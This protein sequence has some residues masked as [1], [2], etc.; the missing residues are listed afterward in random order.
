MQSMNMLDQLAPDGSFGPVGEIR[1][2]GRPRHLRHPA[3][4]AALR[5]AAVR[6]A[7]PRRASRGA[8]A[9]AASS[10][11]PS[12][13]RPA[14]DLAA[15]P[16]SRTS[17]HSPAARE[18][19]SSP[20]ISSNC[21]STIGMDS[22]A[23]VMSDLVE[24]LIAQ[25]VHPEQYYAELGP[26]QQELPVRFT[27]ALRAADNQITVRETARGVALKHGLV[28]SFAPKPF[29]D[30]AG[31]RRPHPLQPVA[32]RRMVPTTFT[33]SVTAMVS[34]RRATASSAGSGSPARPGGPDR[35]ERQLV[36]SPAA[37]LL[38]ERLHRLGP[39][40]PR[41]SHPDSRRSGVAW[42]W[43]PPTWS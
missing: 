42:K 24:A 40:Q 32:A 30:Q 39:R 31:Q 13:R 17:S 14:G 7:D 25:G 2:D 37:T 36:S 5:A 34:P 28:A 6:H 10:S 27:E 22:A 20:W 19:P 26:G 9:R 3:I 15:A 18:A 4:R 41:G 11:E 16:P 8:P 33:T 38:V 35:A 29:P 23:P 21:F 12:P 43:S 1:L